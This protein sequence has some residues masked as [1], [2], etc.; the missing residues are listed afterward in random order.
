MVKIKLND[1]T[2]IEALVVN[3][4][5]QYIKGYNRE[6]L[7]FVFNAEGNSMDVLSKTFSDPNKTRKIT[8]INGS[9]EYIHTGYIVH[10]QKLISLTE[11]LVEQETNERPARYEKRI[12]VELAQQTFS[13][14]KLEELEE[15]FSKFAN[16]LK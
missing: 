10:T 9:E 7:E 15:S 4:S 8:I 16:L 12:K 14:K 13:E 6:V 2:Q 11:D 5:T 3:S 1:N